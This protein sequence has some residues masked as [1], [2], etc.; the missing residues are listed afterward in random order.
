MNTS[1]VDTSKYSLCA[2]FFS[3]LLLIKAQDNSEKALFLIHSALSSSPGVN[4]SVPS[5]KFALFV[6]SVALSDA[7]D[8][9]DDQAAAQFAIVVTNL[10]D[11]NCS[12][13]ILISEIIEFVW[14]TVRG[15]LGVD[16]CPVG[17]IL[18]QRLKPV[19]GAHWKTPVNALEERALCILACNWLQAETQ[20]LISITPAACTSPIGVI[21]LLDMAALKRAL[22]RLLAQWVSIDDIDSYVDTAG[23][24]GSE[25]APAA[26][27]PCGSFLKT[28]HLSDDVD[29]SATEWFNETLPPCPLPPFSDEEAGGVVS[30]DMSVVLPPHLAIKHLTPSPPSLTQ[31]EQGGERGEAWL[32]RVLLEK[33]VGVDMRIAQE[34]SQAIA[35]RARVELQM[36]TEDVLS[37][38]QREEAGRGVWGRRPVGGSGGVWEEEVVRVKLGEIQYY[39]GSPVDAAGGETGRGACPCGALGKAPILCREGLPACLTVC[40]VGDRYRPKHTSAASS[41]CFSCAH[42]R[43]KL[44]MYVQVVMLGVC[45]VCWLSVAVNSEQ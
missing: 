32:T 10:I 4:N 24:P 3:K 16:D 8:I 30:L 45:G 6:K 36:V 28:L 29:T 33:A 39:G 17:T 41:W 9:S 21:Y 20:I 7:S 11:V 44:W 1:S 37:Q 18:R 12:G 13:E 35:E 19:L 27:L 38:Q 5:W 22:R 23:V 43:L 40:R 42:R 14:P 26:S 34:R 2:K 31:R 15:R 25:S